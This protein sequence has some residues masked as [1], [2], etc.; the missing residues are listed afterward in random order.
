[1]KSSQNP[2]IFDVSVPDFQEKVLDMSC[3]KPVLVDLWADWCSPCVVI[4]PIL[5]QVIEEF[6][7]DVLLAKVEVDEGENMKLAGHYHVRG[8]PTVILFEDGEE[9][10]R[11][12]GAKPKHFIEQ[13]IEQHSG[14]L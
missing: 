7:G 3:S 12:S 8:F 13:F 9:K 4:A 11:F 1:M 14:K 5:F 10:G 6:D 2:H